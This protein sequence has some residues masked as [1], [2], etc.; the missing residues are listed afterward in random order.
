MYIYIGLRLGLYICVCVCVCVYFLLIQEYD[1][2]RVIGK[3]RSLLKLSS[4]LDEEGTRLL[5]EQSSEGLQASQLADLMV[6]INAAHKHLA[7]RQHQFENED[8]DVPFSSS[9]VNNEQTFISFSLEVTRVRTT[10]K[11]V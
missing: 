1:A 2:R 6:A 3:I 8:D 10:T 4:K 7:P 9:A 5:V 11:I